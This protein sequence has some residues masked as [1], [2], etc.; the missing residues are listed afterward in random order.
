[1]NSMKSLKQRPF[2]KINL[3]E[4]QEIK[5]LGPARPELVS[6]SLRQFSNNWYSK[7]SWLTGCSKQIEFIASLAFYLVSPIK[8]KHGRNLE[9]MIGNTCLRKQ[10]SM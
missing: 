5:R 3:E 1:M 8:K 4:M 2:P 10:R 9:S 7:Y 6:Q